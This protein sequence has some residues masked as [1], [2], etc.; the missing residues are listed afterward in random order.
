MRLCRLSS[1]VA[2]PW[3][4]LVVPAGCPIASCR[5]LIAPPSLLLVAPA[6]CRF[7]YRHP[8]IALPYHCLVVPAGCR[9]ASRRPLVVPPS[10]QLVVPAGCCIASCRPL[11]VPPSR[12][13]VA[14]ACCRI[15]SPCPLVAPRIAL[16]S[17]HCADWLLLRLSTRRPLF[18]SSS[19]CAASRCLVAPAG[20]RAII[21][22]RPL[23]APTSRPL[24]M[25]GGCCI[26]CPSA[27][28]LS[29]RCIPSPMPSNTVECC[30]RHQ[31]PPPLPP[32]NAVSTAA[33]AAVHHH[34]QMPT[35]TFVRRRRQTLTPTITTRHC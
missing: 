14:P 33:T 30:C 6:G 24:I 19:R 13:L 22:C 29:S 11:V 35:P 18:V 20:C 27:A 4:H 15:T 10:R 34:C 2:P 1:L 8:L 31:T 26:T 12:Q 28:L 9:F 32:L 5:P 23:V 17:S 16:T 3:C 21:Y 25:L 7:A